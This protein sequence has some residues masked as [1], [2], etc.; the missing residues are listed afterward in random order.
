MIGGREEL[1]KLGSNKEEIKGVV[2]ER[3]VNS[4]RPELMKNLYEKTLPNGLFCW[5]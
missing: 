5:P 1:A 2:E 4:Q 3:S